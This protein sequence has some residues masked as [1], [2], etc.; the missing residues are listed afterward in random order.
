MTWIQSRAERFQFET[1]ARR[2][3]DSSELASA[4]S[5]SNP[6]SVCS[7]VLDMGDGGK[8][9]LKEIQRLKARQ[10]SDLWRHARR[11]ALIRIGLA[12]R[13]RQAATSRNQNDREIG[14]RNA[15]IIQSLRRASE[16]RFVV[17]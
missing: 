10:C 15:T 5:S 13:A 2:S 8:N 6:F 11:H 16:A 17:S 9:S 4:H 12:P 7:A 14:T 3:R 1:R